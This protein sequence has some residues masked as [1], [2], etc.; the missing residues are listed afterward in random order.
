MAEIRITETGEDRLTEDN[1]TRVVDAS[2][3]FDDFPMTGVLNVNLTFSGG[4]T[5]VNLGALSVTGALTVTPQLHTKPA[6][7]NR[8]IPPTYLIWVYNLAGE[9]VDVIS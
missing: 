8:P 4:A 7:I 1:E 6:P 3:Y 2:V 9:K 5:S